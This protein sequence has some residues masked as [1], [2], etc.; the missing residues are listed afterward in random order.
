MATN[1]KSTVY[2]KVNAVDNDIS[3]GDVTIKK[4]GSTELILTVEEGEYFKDQYDNEFAE[5][6]H[7]LDSADYTDDEIVLTKTSA[8][9]I[10]YALIDNQ[11]SITI[12]YNDNGGGLTN[13]LAGEQYVKDP[14]IAGQYINAKVPSGAVLQ[15]RV[16]DENG[17]EIMFQEFH[18]PPSVQFTQSAMS[19]DSRYEFIYTNEV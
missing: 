12:Q 9:F 18:N 6:V 1:L 7:T 16:Y 8:P 3:E 4:N 2:G 11:S 17:T 13:L 10:G 15:Y 5:G 19:L 14:I